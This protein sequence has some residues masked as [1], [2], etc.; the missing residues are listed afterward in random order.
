MTIKSGINYVF[1][2]FEGMCP[3]KVGEIEGCKLQEVLLLST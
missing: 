1:D 3:Q 2:G